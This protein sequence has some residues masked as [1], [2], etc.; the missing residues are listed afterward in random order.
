MEGIAFAV[1]V[2]GLPAAFNGC[3]QCFEYVQMARSFGEDFSKC[4]L[5][6]EH[7]KLSLCVWGK[8]VGLSKDSGPNATIEIPGEDR[9]SAEKIRQLVELTFE[10][11][12]GCF[13]NAKQLSQRY[14]RQIDTQSTD[15]TDV[16]PY[17]PETD[18][19]SGPRRVHGMLQK[20]ANSLQ[21][22]TNFT[23]KARWA[24]YDKKKFNTLIDDINEMI[25]QLRQ[26]FPGKMEEQMRLCTT[27]VKEIE[28]EEDLRLLHEVIED[29]DDIFKKAVS[30]TL[31]SRGHR[32]D[33]W[34]L[35]GTAQHRVGDDNVAGAE[36]KGHYIS[37][38]TCSGSSNGWLGNRNNG[39]SGK[40]C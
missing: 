7:A 5:R 9:H 8:A 30:D 2:A 25:N 31:K 10:S 1:A 20:F 39:V 28:N 17:D 38:I 18:L 37:N 14:K 27:Q 13:G 33:K 12:Q 32:V 22:G 24:L 16:A 11:I 36:G 23:K 29:N 6:L 40:W 19:D 34:T 4:A 21:G 3:L 15:S 26:L 35:E